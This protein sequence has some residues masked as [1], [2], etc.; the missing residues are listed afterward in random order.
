MKKQKLNFGTPLLIAFLLLG[1]LQTCQPI[2]SPDEAPSWLYEVKVDD[3]WGFIDTFGNV[4][5]KPQYKEP[6]FYHE[7]RLFVRDDT[8]ALIIDRFGNKIMRIPEGAIRHLGRDWL[9]IDDFGDSIRFYNLDGKKQLSISR[10]VID[11]AYADFESSNRALVTLRNNKGCGYLNKS[12]EIVFTV[13]KGNPNSFD[14]DTDLAVVEFESQTCYIDTMGKTKFCVKGKGEKF[15]KGYALVRDGN[16]KYFINPFGKK[17][18]DVSKYA[19][20]F[21]FFDG[22]AL[23]ISEKRGHRLIN[24]KGEDFLPT[25][26]K[27]LDYPV[28]GVLPAEIN[29]DG[30]SKYV[31]INLRGEKVLDQEYDAMYFWGD[32]N[33]IGVR[34]GEKTGFI[35]HRGQFVWVDPSR[36]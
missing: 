31:L 7:N 23:A 13:T 5:V 24:I 26:Y 15:I 28:R 22:V 18:L 9:S 27:N 17:V 25:K 3:K 35:N 19:D 20:V 4:V 8:S 10:R 2:P 21:P 36:N 1:L 32:G 11:C 12:G 33:L 16:A 14:G 6:G 34:L 30:K 29:V